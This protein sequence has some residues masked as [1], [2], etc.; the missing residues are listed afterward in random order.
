MTLSTDDW[1]KLS[2]GYTLTPACSSVQN[3]LDIIQLC[4]ILQL[5]FTEYGNLK[6]KVCQNQTEPHICLALRKAMFR[7]NIERAFASN[8]DGVQKE[9]QCFPCPKSQ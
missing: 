8:H 2:P 9:R 6:H 5:E 4:D 3:D 1:I 7:K